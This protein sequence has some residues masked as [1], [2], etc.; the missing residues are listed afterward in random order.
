M[1]DHGLASTSSA[2]RREIAEQVGLSAATM[3]AV[4]GDKAQY[5]SDPVSELDVERAWADVESVEV[6]MGAGMT[7]W[8]RIQALISLKSF[9]WSWAR[10]TRW[11]GS[12]R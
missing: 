2:T 12:R 7:R 10:F 4:L 6:E 5:S 1:T 9:G 8:Q 11:P 3:V